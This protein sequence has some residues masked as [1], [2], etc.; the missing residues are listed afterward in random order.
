MCL[1]CLETLCSDTENFGYQVKPID[2][3]VAQTDIDRSLVDSLRE[4]RGILCRIK[5]D[6]REH[7]ASLKSG[8]FK[9]I[10]AYLQTCHLPRTV[11]ECL[12]C[13][14]LQNFVNSF[15]VNVRRQVVHCAAPLECRR[16]YDLPKN[17]S[18]AVEHDDLYLEETLCVWRIYY[19]DTYQYWTRKA[20]VE[21]LNHVESRNVP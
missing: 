8:K 6:V 4:R 16:L 9:K 5:G 13:D 12:W 20:S 10:H 2:L 21:V 18:V 11:L 17:R 14:S 19:Q 3:A 1:K 7:H 15:Q